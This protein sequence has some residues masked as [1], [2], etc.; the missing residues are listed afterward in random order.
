[1][2]TIPNFPQG[3]LAEHARW[4]HA[5]HHDNPSVLPP[6]YGELFLRFHRD[7]IRRALQ[8]YHQAGYDPR[9]VAAWQEVPEPIR[10][11]ACY[12]MQAEL[13]IRNAPQSFA[14]IDEL[15]RFI[16]G[17]NLHGC[18]HQEAARVFGEPDLNDFDVAP[19]NTIFY[20][21]H[22]MID[23]WYRQW[24]M[25]MGSGRSGGE[26]GTASAGARE[27]NASGPAASSR[28][29]Q[30]SV[31]SR[32]TALQRPAA[33]RGSARKKSAARPT[34][35]NARRGR[36]TAPLLSGTAKPRKSGR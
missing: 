5:N 13:R 19:R 24:E 15:G 20:N 14:S 6:G 17:S 36:R 12:P 27:G 8:W 4:H 26:E 33:G 32:P 28:S 18:I 22:G 35:Q 23:N 21:I 3:L 7:Y 31:R 16:E 29:R 2:S 34:Q 11:S 9:L 25:A 1:M 30:A 10:R